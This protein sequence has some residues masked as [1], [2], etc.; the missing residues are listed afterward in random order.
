MSV[1]AGWRTATIGGVVALPL[2]AGAANSATPS[3][4]TPVS[5]PTVQGLVA[6]GAKIKLVGRVQRRATDLGYAEGPLWL[7]GGRLIVSDVYANAVLVFD[8][9]G[10]RGTFRRP[11]N[12]ANGH[13]LD[14]HGSVVE[15]DA[16]DHTHH[17]QITRIA[18]DGAVTVLADNFQGKHFNAP[19]DLIVKRD[20]TIWF[21]DPDYNQVTPAEIEFHGVYRLD[22]KTGSVTLVTKSLNE[23]NGIAFSPDQKTLYVSDTG[24][25]NISA[26]PVRANGTVGAPHDIGENGDG[27]DGIAVDERG[28]IWSSTCDAFIHV[29]TPAGK[30]IGE[31]EFPGATTNLAWGGA[32]GKILFVTT[33]NGRIYSLALTVR[34]SA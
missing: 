26:F 23:P 16:G 33:G 13:A 27:C 10:K 11:S 28:D 12:V 25:A 5:T 24:F 2:A 29:L 30:K 14:A 21:T 4:A 9:T 34:A 18:S 7:S 6:P 8:A 1:R 19:N 15:A 17:G 31:I 32:N 20:G 22:P 3:A